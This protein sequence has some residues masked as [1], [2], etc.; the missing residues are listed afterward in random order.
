MSF[1]CSLKLQKSVFQ[2]L[3]STFVQPCMQRDGLAMVGFGLNS[4]SS[5]VATGG[6][7]S[8][9]TIRYKS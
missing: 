7:L 5:I 4:G 3:S 8:E 2:T 9:L 1:V 6:S